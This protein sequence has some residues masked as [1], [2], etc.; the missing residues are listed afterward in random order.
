MGHHAGFVVAWLL[1]LLRSRVPLT[2][3]LVLSAAVSTPVMADNIATA[4]I[5]GDSLSQMRGVV[6]INQAAGDANAQSNSRAIAI[7]RDGGIAIADTIDRQQA[8]LNQVAMPDVAV[9]RIG[10]NALSGT[11]GLI[12]INQTSGVQNIQLNAAAIA[13][14]INGELSDA[15]L[16]RTLSDAPAVVPDSTDSVNTQRQVQIDST[17]FV[18]AAGLV[19]LNQT[20]GSGNISSNRFEMA[21]NP[22]H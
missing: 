20:A 1:G 7:S 18:G 21:T 3:G 12:G 8:S 9:T 15:T 6:G 22:I 19:Q 13:M 14:S 17:A 5:V 2:A 11:H 4:E 16:A 10:D